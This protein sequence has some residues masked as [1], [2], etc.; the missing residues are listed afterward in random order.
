[1]DSYKARI[2]NVYVRTT[3][4]ADDH[5]TATV[6]ATVSIVGSGEQSADVRILDPAGKE[7]AKST[8]TFSDSSATAIFD[9]T[10]P[11]LWWPN[12]QGEQHLHSLEVTLSNSQDVH[13]SRF[14]V[15]TITVIQEPLA[16]GEPGSTFVFRVNGRDIFAQGGNWIPADT[17]LPTVTRQRYFDWVQNARDAHMNM[18]RVWG[19]GIYEHDDFFDACDELGLLVWHDYEFACTNLPV[20]GSF[21]KSFQ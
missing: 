11:Q 8:V 10:D 14:G 5:K 3:K 9:L 13:K 17:L 1:M 20:H 7:I 2:D 12:G 4:L 18:L 6:A 16:D 21:L 19:G 15:R